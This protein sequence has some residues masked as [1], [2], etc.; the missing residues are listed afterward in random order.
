MLVTQVWLCGKSLSCTLFCVL[1]CMSV[2]VGKEFL[3]TCCSFSG[4]VLWSVWV[5]GFPVSVGLPEGANWGA[6]VWL[7]D[8]EALCPGQDFHLP[9]KT[10]HTFRTHFQACMLNEKLNKGKFEK[11]CTT[12][13]TP[14][15]AIFINCKRKNFSFSEFSVFCISGVSKE[16]RPFGASHVS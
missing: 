10:S 3:E 8:L 16:W 2:R 7:L 6:Q 12:D 13:R 11:P 9:W 1:F 4:S 5:D 14:H 15:F